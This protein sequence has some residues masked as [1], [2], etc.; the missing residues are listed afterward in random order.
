M[1]GGRRALYNL[2][3][4]TRPHLTRR[5][6]LG[7]TAACAAA[8]SGVAAYATFVEPFAYEVNARDVFLPNL[9]A[10]FDNFRITQLSDVHHSRY[11][12]L[13]EVSRVVEL[14]Q[15]AG[16]DMIVLT[17]D[18]TTYSRRFIEPCV[19]L[20]G[21]L[22]ATHG[23][24]AVLG[25]HDHATDPA[26]TT[27]ALERAG[28][29]VLSN[30]WTEIERDGE[31]LPLVGVDDWSWGR[32]R[33]D[34]AQRGLDARRVSIL[35]SHQPRV[36]DMEPA[37]K[38]SLILAGHTHGGQVKLPFVGAPVRFAEEFKYVEGFFRRAGTQL[39]VTRGTG[40]VGLPVRIGTPPEI[41]LIRLRRAPEA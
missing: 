3:L 8:A 10:S 40:V 16:G 32:L 31:R 20:L 29:P 2:R 30:R 27:R 5:G 14:T 6:F 21:N 12:S 41:S 1:P 18:Y 13:D 19:E 26:R 37:L 38:H 9:P 33:W 7:F 24:W 39:F 36:L 4:V 25:N 22:S 34:E 17:G 35:L 28:I 11:V 15:G 23:V